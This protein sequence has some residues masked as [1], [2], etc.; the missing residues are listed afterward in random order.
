MNKEMFFKQ[1][2]EILCKT[3]DLTM[4]DFELL[5]SYAISN[6]SRSKGIEIADVIVQKLAGHTTSDVLISWDF[7]STEVGKALLKVRFEIGSDILFLNDIVKLTG[8]SKAAVSKAMSSGVLECERRDGKVFTKEIYV[9]QYLSKKGVKVMQ[10][11]KEI[12]YDEAIEQ[13][14]NPGYER[15]KEYK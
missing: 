5:Y 6:K 15:E 2:N 9:K 12:S 7:L 13:I 4:E 3:K 11:N 14:V 10:E 8:T 1:A